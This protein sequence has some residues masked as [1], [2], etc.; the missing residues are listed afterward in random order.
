[1]SLS[2]STSPLCVAAAAIRAGWAAIHAA[3]AAAAVSASSTPAAAAACP[4]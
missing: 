4:I 2:N 1:M 3:L